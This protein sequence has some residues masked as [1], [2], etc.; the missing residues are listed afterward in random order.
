MIERHSPNVKPTLEQ[1]IRAALANVNVGS[2]EL[3]Q[4]I[5]ETETAAAA[6]ASSAEE[7][8]TSVVD[9]VA[10]PDAKEARERLLEVEL[11]RDRLGAALP[12]LH[13][14]LAAVLQSEH[15]ERWLNR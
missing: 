11:E 5:P 6:A 2:E 3:Q 13:S 12:R 8:R 4:L 15:H 1:R 10:T 7:L 9:L 14:A